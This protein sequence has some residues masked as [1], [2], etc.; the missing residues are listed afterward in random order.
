MSLTVE[1]LSALFP[2]DE[3][4]NVCHFAYDSDLGKYV[5]DVVNREF[6]GLSV[7][8]RQRRIW[9]RIRESFGSDLQEIS[10]VLAFSPEEYVEAMDAA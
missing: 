8:E 4:G 7:A 6:R 9:D 2:S 5:G 10:L 3:N 1:S